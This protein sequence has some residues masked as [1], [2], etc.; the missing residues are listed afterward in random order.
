ME[1]K[2]TLQQ[3][4]AIHKLFELLSDELNTKGLDMK[5]VLKP[6]YQIWWT[7]EAVKEHLWKPLQEAMY[8]KKSTTE[9]NTAQVSKVYEQLGKILGEKFGAEVEF[10][11]YQETENYLK[12]F[13]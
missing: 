12:S 4:K 9:L 13:E 2:R 5:L 3:N 10:P 11:S 7:P 8:A 6:S 1:T